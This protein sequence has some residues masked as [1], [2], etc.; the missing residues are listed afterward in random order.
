MHLLRLS[1]SQDKCNRIHIGRQKGQ[2]QNLK[3]HEANMKESEL[4][5][6]L[7]DLINALGDINDTVEQRVS[8]GYAVI[9]EI[10]AIFSEIP[11]GRH[12]VEIGM[13]LRQAMLLN[14]IL[15]N[16]EAWHGVYLKHVNEFEKL[17]EHL[18][19]FILGAH[20]KTP[21]EM[22]YLES[23][24]I[25]IRFVLAS[26]RVNYYVNIMK[27]N[28]SE[29]TK[30]IV[31]EQVQNP[32]EGDFF[33]LVKK[34]CQSLDIPLQ[35]LDTES[36]KSLKKFVKQ[37][38]MKA[39][40]VYLKEKQ[41]KHSKVRNIEYNEVK[42]QEYLKSE[43]ITEKESKLLFSLRTRTVAGVKANFPGMFVDT[44]CPFECV[45]KDG[46]PM[47]DT[48]EHMLDCE[49]QASLD[50]T[51]DPLRSVKYDDIFSKNCDKMKQAANMF[52]RL[53]ETRNNLMNQT[54]EPN[55]G[56]EHSAS[57]AVVT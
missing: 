44:H 39:A 7:G 5:K 15:F 45:D 55:A 26:R 34:D 50:K 19:R 14:G 3:V 31:K 11:L 12:K 13:E 36:Q 23:G 2:C 6:Y 35:R 32:L 56:P 30:R 21:C 27:R 51:I 40:T 57:S 28:D 25:P 20:P 1:L 52:A 46:I 9:A 41:Q 48:Q 29:L 33:S 49:R 42:T 38:V 16:S 54:S 8:R 4:E 43:K 53:L 10:R 24:A 37:Q 47:P 17:D 22:L 18:L